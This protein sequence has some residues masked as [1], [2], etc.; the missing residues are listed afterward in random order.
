M[1][2]YVVKVYRGDEIKVRDMLMKRVEVLKM[3]DKLGKILV[4]T[5]EE[6]KVVSGKR[7]VEERVKYP[8]YMFI[9]SDDDV[10]FFNV[11]R[12]TPKVLG[13]V[14]DRRNIPL[15]VIE[16]DMEKV[17]LKEDIKRDGDGISA[18][19]LIKIVEGPFVG[20][21]GRVEREIVNKMKLRIIVDIFGRDTV[22]EIE[23]DK[24]IL[25]ES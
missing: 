16:E 20:F 12:E 2:W 8:G 5:V 1:N 3:T 4:P 17:F 7:R 25:V 23:R 10:E 6:I 22:I 18:G 11:V 21:I 19:K 15:K 24:V 14:S 13:I 9:Y